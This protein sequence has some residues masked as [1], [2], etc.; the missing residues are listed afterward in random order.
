VSGVGRRHSQAIAAVAGKESIP[1]R[2][3]IFDCVN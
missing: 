3:N 1:A 2:Y